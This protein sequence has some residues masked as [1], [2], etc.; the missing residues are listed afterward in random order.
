MACIDYG[1]VAF[2]N[3]KRVS[4]GLFMDMVKAV[5]WSDVNRKRYEDCDHVDADG[6]SQCEGC[7]RAKYG[8]IARGD[9]V[10]VY[11]DADC[12][13]NRLSF[14]GKCDGNYFV[15]IGDKHITVCFYKYSCVIYEDGAEVA[16]IW[17]CDERMSVR[18]EV[19]VHQ[20][21]HGWEVSDGV[22][23]IKRLGRGV[24]HFTMQYKGDVYHVVYGYGIDN[25]KRVWDRIKNEWVGKKTA[26]KV[27]RI[28]SRFDWNL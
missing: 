6:W 16:H 14:S 26:K 19:G 21:E 1:A 27:D 22:Y 3:G 8:Q 25:N 7:V 23:H 13:G 4:D 15:Y 10:L 5:G 28:Y 9:D 24:Y 18:G 11:F 20:D 2:K 12:R 17:D